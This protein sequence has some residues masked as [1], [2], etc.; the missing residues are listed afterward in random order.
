MSI[1]ASV[2]RETRLPKFRHKKLPER[3]EGPESWSGWKKCDL[4]YPLVNYC[5]LG[6]LVAAA[7]LTEGELR[8]KPGVKADIAR[9]RMV[10]VR[11]KLRESILRTESQQLG[12]DAGQVGAA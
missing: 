4:G 3:L 1:G 5:R 10:A 11:A 12:R 8:N 6:S 2:P 7:Y 9:V